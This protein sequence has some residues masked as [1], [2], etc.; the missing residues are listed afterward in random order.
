DSERWKRTSRAVLS[1][2]TDRSDTLRASQSV[3][4]RRDLTQIATR[5]LIEMA[6]CTCPSRGGRKVTESDTDY[7]LAQI[8]VLIGAASRS[9]AL[10]AG[11]TEPSISISALGEFKIGEEVMELMHEYLTVHYEQIHGK[12]VLGYEQFFEARPGGTKT[13]VEVFGSEFVDAFSEE[14]GISPQSLG[15]L[16]V[17]LCENAI[18]AKKLVIKSTHEEFAVLL[19]N[20][21]LGVPQ[22][23]ALYNNFVLHPR[24]RWDSAEKPFRSKDWWPW[25]FRRRLSMMTRPIINLGADGV[26][27][28]PA[29]CEDSF[30]HVVM[31]AYTGGAETEYFHSQRMKAYVGSSNARRGLAF[32]KAVADRLRDLGFNVQ[33][34]VEMKRFGADP[35]TATGDIDVLA[36]NNEVALIC[37]CKELNFA[38]TLG[39][40]AEQLSR[41]RGVANDELTKHLRRVAWFTA[42]PPAL[43]AFTK[44]SELPIRSLLITSKTVPMQFAKHALVEVL[45]INELTIEKLKTLTRS[46]AES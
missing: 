6:V 11:C 44:L 9:D 25:R 15:K 41:F 29:F 1:V 23:D 45:T 40:V 10:R 37:E 26:M 4:E 46:A 30:R 2:H 24:T 22:I 16:G 19:N 42:H 34:E 39:E 8:T 33:T 3:K 36:W 20:S 12:D 38:R 7:L 17:A 32:N 18:E 31:E 5:I 28:A 43:S 14:Y 21:D 27:Y 13:D 35:S